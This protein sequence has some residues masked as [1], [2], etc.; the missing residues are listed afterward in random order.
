[1][2]LKFVRDAHAAGLLVASFCTGNNIAKASG[3]IDFPYGP[4]LFP[5]KVILIKE[6]VLLG[7]GDGGYPPEED[8]RRT[9]IKEFCDAVARQLEKK[10]K[11]KEGR[12]KIIDTGLKTL[13]ILKRI[14]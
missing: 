4:A 5:G 11:G 8:S 12:L 9:L 2:V 10:R 1:M 13:Q 3:L 6:R 7:P 14:A